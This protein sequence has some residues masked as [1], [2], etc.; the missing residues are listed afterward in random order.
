MKPSCGT[1]WE[2]V[3]GIPDVS[4]NFELNQELQLCNKE[5]TCQSQILVYLAFNSSSLNFQRIIY[6]AKLYI[7]AGRQGCWHPGTFPRTC[8]RG[9]ID[10]TSG[11]WDELDVFRLLFSRVHKGTLCDYPSFYCDLW[12]C[13]WWGYYAFRRGTFAVK[14]FRHSWASL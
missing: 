14:N 7:C 5:L 6:W 10:L 13:V 11:Q 1:L 9:A 3:S 4:H 8:T 2:S 12:E